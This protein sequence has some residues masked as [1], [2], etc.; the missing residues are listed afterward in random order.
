M[1]SRL[2]VGLALVWATS[3]G[4]TA[5]T[6]ADDAAAD[7]ST[8]D[9]ATSD[10]ADDSSSSSMAIGAPDA[11][12]D[13]ATTNNPAGDCQEGGAYGGSRWTDL[14]Q[15]YF[16]PSGPDSCSGQ[17]TMC[18]ATADSQGGADWVC[19]ATSDSCYMGMVGDPSIDPTQDSSDPTNNPL[20]SIL[21]QTNG[22]GF[23]PYLCLQPA[24]LF[25]ADMA[26]I[27][28]WIQAGG[29]EN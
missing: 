11:G 8:H 2:L 17:G 25:P 16:G 28:A 29:T 3:A 4:C 26:R 27:A 5:A 14:Y 24:Q 20:Y 1:R 15:C 13:G 23:M 6:S 22:D 9:S 19:G 10:G 7:A 21:C 12:G 18:H